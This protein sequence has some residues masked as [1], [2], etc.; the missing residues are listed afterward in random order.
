MTP[1][2]QVELQDPIKAA[3]LID[4]L[5]ENALV[6]A[7]ESRSWPVLYTNGN[8]VTRHIKK[9][10][11]DSHKYFQRSS[12]HTPDQVTYDQLRSLLYIN[13]TVN[14]PKYVELME[15]AVLLSKVNDE[16]EIYWLGF[17]TPPLSYSREFIE[18]IANREEGRRFMV[19]SQPVDYANFKLRK[20]YVRGRY[21]SWEIVEEREDG[22]VEW[23]CIQYSSA[24]GYLPGF[25]SDFVAGKDFHKDVVSVLK[26]IHKDNNREK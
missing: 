12:I 8:V 18:L 17:K 20:G 1:I 11:K 14:E 10:S 2:S 9:S 24:G 25:V 21:Q 22:T 26:R 5:F 7:K 23:I 15:E 4:S 6:L 3:E 16:A 13:H 19:V